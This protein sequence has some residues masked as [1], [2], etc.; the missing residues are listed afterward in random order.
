MIVLWLTYCS[1]RTRPWGCRSTR[2]GSLSPKPTWCSSPDYP[3]TSL[4][5][6]WT[7]NSLDPWASP[8]GVAHGLLGL[9]LVDGLKN[10]ASQRFEAVASLSWAVEFSQA[11]VS[12]RSDSRPP[13][14]QRQAL[15][16]TRRSRHSDADRGNPEWKRRGAAGWDESAD[17]SNQGRQASTGHGDLG[18]LQAR[19]L[20]RIIAPMPQRPE[21]VRLIATL[22]CHV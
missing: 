15:D 21:S 10:R 14:R 8:A 11:A 18:H 5:C 16:A 1:T 20:Y 4:L 7:T 3:G 19:P 17:G 9:I 12:G 22:N 2:R 13:D 6:T